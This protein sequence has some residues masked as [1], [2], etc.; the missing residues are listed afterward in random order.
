LYLERSGFKGE[1]K[2][3]SNHSFRHMALTR[4]AKEEG[5]NI[6]KLRA[7]H[8]S[9]KTTEKYFHYNIDDYLKESY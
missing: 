4:I 2:R 9:I 6:A 3:I 8:K 7:G 1:V 5:M